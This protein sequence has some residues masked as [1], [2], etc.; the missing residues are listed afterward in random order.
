MPCVGI[1][2]GPFDNYPF[3]C[4]WN[5]RCKKTI[6]E[7]DIINKLEKLNWINLT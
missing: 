3:K 1:E 6:D 2:N 4:P 5:I 7:I